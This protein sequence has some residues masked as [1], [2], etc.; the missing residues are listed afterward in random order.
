M[1]TRLVTSHRE[2]RNGVA[3]SAASAKVAS[4][5]CE[6]TS[7][8]DSC[9]EATSANGDPRHSKR[10]RSNRAEESS[11]GCDT[12]V[13]EPANK[14]AASADKLN[15]IRAVKGRA[16]QANFSMTEPACSC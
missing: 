14:L 16:P 15:M 7:A 4:G 12:G 5:A 3:V 2:R 9:S 13:P 10:G 8:G 6:N 1:A 11:E